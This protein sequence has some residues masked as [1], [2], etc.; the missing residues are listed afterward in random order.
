[1]SIE[2]KQMTIKSTLVSDRGLQEPSEISTV[3]IESLKEML[4]EECREMIEQNL[5]ELRER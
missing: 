2:I 3:D 1:M 4:I 5:S